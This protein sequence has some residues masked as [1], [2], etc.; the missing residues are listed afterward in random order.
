MIRRKS[1][2]YPS[3]YYL[4]FI[5]VP[6]KPTVVWLYGVDYIH[7]VLYFYWSEAYVRSVHQSVILGCV[8]RLVEYLL[9]GHQR[10]LL[11]GPVR[12]VLT[13]VTLACFDARNLNFVFL[14]T[15]TYHFDLLHCSLRWFA[16]FAVADLLT[17]G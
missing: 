2:L 17:C 8:R 1:I 5:T 6:S 7:Y 10:G 11:R 9:L 16:A 12:I 15:I 14:L 13:Q 3:L 4:K